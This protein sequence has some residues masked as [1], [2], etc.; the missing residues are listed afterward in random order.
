MGIFLRAPRGSPLDGEGLGSGVHCSRLFDPILLQAV[1]E[2]LVL[3][4]GLGCGGG[5][6]IV[7]ACRGGGIQGCRGK[8]RSRAGHQKPHTACA[9][10]R[11]LEAAG[12]EDGSQEGVPTRF[13]PYAESRTWGPAPCGQGEGHRLG[14]LPPRTVRRTIGNQAPPAAIQNTPQRR[15]P[16]GDVSASS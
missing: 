7:G 14:H 3:H 12:A 13:S 1:V 11:V 16:K 15:G 9:R 8:D 10:A 4:T 5:D 6:G 2:I